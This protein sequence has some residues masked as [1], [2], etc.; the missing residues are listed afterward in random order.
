MPSLRGAYLPGIAFIANAGASSMQTQM[1]AS[2]IDAED[3][4]KALA[5]DQAAFA[6]LYD[7]YFNRVYD[8][9]AR[10]LRDRAAAEDV[11]QETFIHALTA[12]PSLKKPEGFRSWLFMSAR[13]RALD[14]MD[15]DKRV[16]AMPTRV[17]SEG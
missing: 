12:L 11:T 13:N 7:R 5:G 4:C 1:T 16:R 3:V 6:S 9:L 8:F 2:Q 10:M 14:R 15:R 17:T